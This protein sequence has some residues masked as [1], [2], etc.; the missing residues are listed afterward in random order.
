MEPLKVGHQKGHHVCRREVSVSHFG[1]AYFCGNVYLGH[2][3][4]P[5]EL[6]LAVQLV[7]QVRK[8]NERSSLGLITLNYSPV[9]KIK[10]QWQENYL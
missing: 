5:S 7:Q 1:G 4:T 6:S 8:A 2:E 3:A 10:Q 9:I